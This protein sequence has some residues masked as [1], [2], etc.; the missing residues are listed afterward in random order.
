M[1]YSNEPTKDYP[2]ISIFEALFEQET[3]VSDDQKLY[4]D[5][6]NT[7]EYL[8][9]ASLKRDILL[10]AQ[11]LKNKYNFGPGDIMAICAPN[12]ASATTACVRALEGPE[13]V[14]MDITLVRP[15]LIIS[16]KD[17]IKAVELAA[18][19]IG[20]DDTHILLF[21]NESIKGF[22]P[23]RSVLMN[24]SVLATPVKLTP[25]EL[26]TEPAYLYYT[27]G[28][29]GVKKAT[30]ITHSNVVAMMY[31]N[32]PWVPPG[33]PYLAYSNNAHISGLASAMT[34]SIMHGIRTYFLRNFSIQR[35]CEAV[36][37]YKIRFIMSQAWVGAALTKESFV[38][39]YDLS[40][41]L[42][43]LSAG[44]FLDQTTMARFRERHNFGL[45][46]VFGMT[47][48]MS[49]IKISREAHIRGSVG[50]LY[51]GMIAKI[52]DDNGE[53]ATNGSPGELCLKG[54]TV[55]PGYYS[56]PKATAATIDKDNF[57]HSGDLFRVDEEGYFYYMSRMKDRI[58]YY[59]YEFSPPEIE[60]VVITHPEVS[61]CCVVGVYSEEL[62][63]E[64]PKAF[65]VLS[66]RQSPKVTEEEIRAYAEDRLPEY[67]RLKGG[68]VII[69]ALPLTFMGK[70]DRSI[71]R[72][73][74]GSLVPL[75]H[76]KVNSI[77]N[78]PS[79]ISI[80]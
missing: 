61:E 51:P 78:L 63:T 57:F 17:T 74:T 48:V 12:H 24:H 49:C 46:S 10:F 25:K 43:I 58:T 37:K 42:L 20:L 39:N 7:E 60:D 45:S 23:F 70:V 67:L 15:K 11:G 34:L 6:D 53:E 71:L 22:K 28:T 32:D 8:T 31:A 47:E 69:D 14:V 26:S 80:E 13:R 77:L 18:Q 62:G 52:I 27:S 40:S 41:L 73:Q 5:C 3:N 66:N 21:G 33:T 16:H 1:Y 9:R 4:V 19:N 68:V 76:Q 35:M 30:I 56:D 38:S 50:R 59:F 55:T 79:I 64:L 54:P 65:V 44:S 29:S 2:A 36:Q 75:K 72:Q